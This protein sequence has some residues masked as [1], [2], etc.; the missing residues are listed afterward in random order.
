MFKPNLLKVNQLS[1]EQVLNPNCPYQ[2]EEA[3]L[4][5]PESGVIWS[6]VSGLILAMCGYTPG[7]MQ[8]S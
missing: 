7:L 6:L 3:V 2:K 4:C 5:L 8:H 1:L